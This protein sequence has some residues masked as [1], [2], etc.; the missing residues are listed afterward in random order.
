[1]FEAA[2]LIINCIHD[3]SKIRYVVQYHQKDKYGKV[4]GAGCTPVAPTPAGGQQRGE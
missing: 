2:S 3:S 4:C 1:V